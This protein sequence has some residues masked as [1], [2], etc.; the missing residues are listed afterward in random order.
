[1]HLMYACRITP[2]SNGEFSD[3]PIF[4]TDVFREDIWVSMPFLMPGLYMK[5]PLQSQ[6]HVLDALQFYGIAH[7]PDFSEGPDR[8]Y[9]NYK[10]HE[11]WNVACF[12]CGE[13]HLNIGHKELLSFH[14]NNGVCLRCREEVK[15]IP[16][17][18]IHPQRDY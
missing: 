13:G 11:R 8:P 4:G 15:G 12:H 18:P 6:W 9:I 5:F 1:M 2:K 10:G 14:L 7:E 3:S 17:E 16:N